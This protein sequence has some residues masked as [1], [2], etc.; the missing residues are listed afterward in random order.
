[1]KIQ[2]LG[3]IGALAFAT[4]VHAAP[5]ADTTVINGYLGGDYSRLTLNISDG[6][7]SHGIDA[8]GGGVAVSAPLSGNWGGQVDGQVHEFSISKLGV[9]G[10]GDQWVVTPTAHGFYRTD[11]W[12]AGGFIGGE[13]ANQISMFGGGV[14]GQ[15]Y[16]TSNVTLE[17]ST[18]YATINKGGT[19]GFW[20]ARL[21]GR[22]FFTNNFS[23]GANANYVNA[24]TNG[25]SDTNGWTG[26]VNGEYK[27]NN[28]PVSL[29][30]AYEHGDLHALGVSSD[31]VKVG[32]RWVPGGTLRD[33]DTKGA[34]L[35]NF[36]DTFGGEEFQGLLGLG[37]SFVSG[38]GIS[39]EF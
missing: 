31:T 34:G 29:T 10:L 12:L 37:S 24:H 6:G 25:F 21:G 18:G 9:E 32:V 8:W 36:S 22:Y 39:C 20:G 5:A 15:V 11:R 4:A 1:M 17:G 14:E 33:R 35:P 2:L 30:L 28:A 27:F 26:G 13:V 16:P 23:V 38:C 19:T 3:A 7:G